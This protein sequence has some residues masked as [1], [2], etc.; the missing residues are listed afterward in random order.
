MKMP[1]VQEAFHNTFETPFDSLT[2]ERPFL[3]LMDLTSFP[4]QAQGDT[5][6]VRDLV[7]LETAVRR[8]CYLLHITRFQLLQ[9][10]VPR[11]KGKKKKKGR[12]DE[13]RLL[14]IES[15]LI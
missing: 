3:T 1:A 11:R 2:P 12:A 10:L 15:D 9:G 6:P 5:I 7:P 4:L 13:L 8:L 14:K